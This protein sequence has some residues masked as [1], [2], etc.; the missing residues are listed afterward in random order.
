MVNQSS[1]RRPSEGI[2]HRIV[3]ALSND[4]DAQEK[5]RVVS[6]VSEWIPQSP[7]NK[8]GAIYD[9]FKMDEERNQKKNQ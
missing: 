5:Q 8:L 1:D 9:I 4:S 2:I 7:A 6:T 3:G